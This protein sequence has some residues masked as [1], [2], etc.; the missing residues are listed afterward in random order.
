MANKSIS[1]LDTAAAVSNNDLFETA[2]PDNG[3]AT[4]YASKKH[5]L[6]AMADHIAT[7]VNYPGLQ[8]TAKALVSAINEAA[9]AGGTTVIA[10]PVGT[11]T[12]DLDTIQI[13][14]TIY[15]I[16]G[17]GGSGLVYQE[18]TITSLTNGTIDTSRG[19]C[20]YARWGN[21]MHLH[22]SVKD[23]TVE[24]NQNVFTIPSSLRPPHITAMGLGIG[25]DRTK[26]ASVS[27]GAAS[28]VCN[29]WSQSTTALIDVEWLIEDS[30]ATGGSGADNYSTTEHVV[31]TWID[32]TPVYEKTVY[33]TNVAYT[34]V[35]TQYE[36][37]SI[38]NLAV[39]VDI[40]AIFSNSGKTIYHSSPYVATDQDMKKSYFDF[41][42]TN[43]RIFFTSQDTW[44]S[45]NMIVTARYT[46]SQA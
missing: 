3:S 37:M 29:L 44:G 28:G 5:S 7:T 20:W 22:L 13:G 41:D 14:S 4:G 18:T 21:V 38:P 45:T 34:T 2:I 10:N 36:V 27:I 31:G 46:K 8:T 30:S 23:L 43:K 19:G 12:D 9:Q 39:P 35:N 15:D 32:G 6:A 26:L 11:P 33:L 1:Q 25:E 24:T 40:M 42:M 16:V 17:S